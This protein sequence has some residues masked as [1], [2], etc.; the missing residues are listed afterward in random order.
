MTFLRESLAS[1][2]SRKRILS[3]AGIMVGART[4]G[5]AFA[6][7]GTAWAA[8]CLGPHQLG[9]SGM[10]QSLVSQAA[11]ILTAIYPTVLVRD[12]KN[13][14]RAE[15]RNRLVRDTTSFKLAGILFFGLVCAAAMGLGMVPSEY[16]L[17]GWFFIPLLLANALQPAWVFQAAEKQ[18]FQSMI[19]V[20]QSA[21]KAACY[22]LLFRAGATA[23][24]DL[25]V[26]TGV[27]VTL[28][29]VYWG[30][31][32]RLTPMRGPLF[33][34]RSFSR[35]VSLLMKSRWLFFSGVCSYVY[36]TLEQPLLGWLCS[37]D[38]LGKYRTA[39]QVV[40][41]AD[42]FFVIIPMILYPRFIEW[43]KRGESVLWG[44]QKKLAVLACA[45]GFSAALAAFVLVPLF[46]PYVFGADFAAAGLPCAILI[47]SK[48]VVVIGGIFYWGL[49]TD[50]RYDRLL[51]LTTLGMAV[52]S[53]L[54]NLLLIPHGGMYAAASVNL[55][56]EAILLAVC[57]SACLRKARDGAARS[58]PRA[59]S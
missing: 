7:V 42:S 46:Y 18:H 25:E 56:S 19:A 39:V 51:S 2:L 59:I 41:A 9:L 30:A 55:A 57:L 47:L 31:I 48:I 49:M 24:A 28:T 21:L 5:L 13:A 29:L 45:V 15:L 50:D 27:T 35:V 58:R 12:Y 14:D 6:F 26:L 40:A 32:Y 20:F 10:V 43:R 16:R 38:E 3:Q 37:V 23:I 36:S 53:L 44:R 52:F 8:R 33:D 11:L 1:L 4:V 22:L 54:S 17:A 34:P